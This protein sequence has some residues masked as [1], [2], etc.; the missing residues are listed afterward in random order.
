ME[1]LS[2]L[3]S[4]LGLSGAAGLNAFIPLL[5]VGLLSRADVIQL[6]APFDLLANPWVLLGVAV[7]GLLDFVGDKIPGVDHVLHVAG[8][9]VNAA[10]GAVLFA[11]QAGVADVPPALSMALGLIVAGGVQATRTAVR[12]VATATTA[13]LGNPVVST[14]ED[15]TSLLLSALAVFAPLLAALL[16]VVIVVGVYRFWSARRVRRLT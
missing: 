6:N 4:S 13:G 15:G 7:V 8:G 10:A 2:G 11:S 14:V 1:L 16:L 5:V 12:P 9:V 3:L